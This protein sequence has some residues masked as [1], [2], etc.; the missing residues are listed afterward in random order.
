ML[1][2]DK[3]IALKIKALIVNYLQILLF[4][5]VRK[6]LENKNLQRKEMRVGKIKV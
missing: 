4:S 6:Q 3:E 5:A 1:L 2:E